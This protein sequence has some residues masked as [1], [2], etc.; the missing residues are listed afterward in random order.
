VIL[1]GDAEALE[2]LVVNLVE[3]AIKYNRVGGT[4]TLR[5]R[6]EATEVVL[7][8]VDTGIGIPEVDRERIFERF[9]RVDRGRARSQGG[10]GLGLAIVKHAV[11]RHGGTLTVESR[12]GEGSTFRVEL[13][14]APGS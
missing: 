4:V 11:R 12:L 2:R 1:T 7:E 3:N 13:P 8:V 10:T 9:Y 14:A 6:A 5:L